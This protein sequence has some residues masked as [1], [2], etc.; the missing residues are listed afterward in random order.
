MLERLF[1]AADRRPWSLA[2]AL[3][4]PVWVALIRILLERALAM[5][6]GRRAPALWFTHFVVF[7][8]TLSVV[9]TAVL[10]VLARLP[11]KQA[12]NQVGM[13]LTLGCVPPLLDT[14]VLGRGHFA[15]E[16]KAWPVPW[17]LTGNAQTIPPGE[18]TVLWL[19]IALMTYAVWRAT[20]RAWRTVLA[21]GVVWLLV[22]LIL[23]FVPQ[24]IG[25]LNE[26]TQL[27]PSDWRNALFGVVAMAAVVTALRQ[28]PRL[29]TRLPQVALPVLFL[30]LG[31]AQR[32][33]ID[34]PAVLGAVHV[35][36]LGIGF[37]L[38]NDW[39]D[40]REDALSGRPT[41]LDEG[42]AQWLALVPLVFTAHVVTTRV[43]LGLAL[44][45]FSIV[46]FAYHADPLRLKCVFPLS[47]KTE[48]FLGGLCFFAGLTAAGTAPSDA[49]LWLLLAVTLGTPAALVFKDYKDIDADAQA[50]VRSAFVVGEAKGASRVTLRRLSAFGLA[51]S[52]ALVALWSGQ[53][54]LLALAAV[55]PAAVL[56]VP[57]PSHAVAGGIVAAEVLLAAAIAAR[58]G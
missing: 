21:A 56:L 52:L 35:A 31:A 49:S 45:G 14:A 24:A 40:R 46:S 32:G 20:K 47:Y 9:L 58:V 48:A 51:L 5:D 7:Y 26:R 4:T 22:L 8:L 16:Y 29:L 39:Y 1:R 34:G 37:T 2:L 3:A 19:V 43:E 36:L 10:V 50:G 38:A 18:T 15:Y 33:V 53:F 11:W 57:K 23:S 6:A 13:G 17:L 28:W 41:T 27:A 44:L 42:A 12:M 30:L 25:P 55:A 54:A